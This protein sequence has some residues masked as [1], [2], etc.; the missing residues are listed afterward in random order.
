LGISDGFGL[1]LKG[2]TI[3]RGLENLWVLWFD[4]FFDGHWGATMKEGCRYLIPRSVQEQ[5]QQRGQTE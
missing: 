1:R 5:Y 2:Q 4:T 3:T